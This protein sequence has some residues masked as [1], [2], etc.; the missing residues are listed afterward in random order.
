VNPDK[1][2]ATSSYNGERF[3]FC[4]QECKD[5]FDAAPERFVNAAEVFEQAG[6]L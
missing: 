2:L 6:R 4:G 5:E 3:T 1:A